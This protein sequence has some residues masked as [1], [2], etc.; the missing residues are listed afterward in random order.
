MPLKAEW[1]EVFSGFM[2]T[3]Q[4]LLRL[5]RT[6]RDGKAEPV[7]FFDHCL[8]ADYLNDGDSSERISR[9]PQ[10]DCFE[11]FEG[12]LFYNMTISRDDML[13]IWPARHVTAKPR[14][15]D[16]EIVSHDVV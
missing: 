1:F 15:S 4:D 16:E 12:S 6:P 14:M 10:T 7:L 8:V 2:P 3:E 5:S 9:G 13:R 11:N